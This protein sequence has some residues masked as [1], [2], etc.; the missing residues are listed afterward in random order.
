MAEYEGIKEIVNQVAAQAPKAI[1]M[2]FRDMDQGSWPAPPQQAKE[3]HKDKGIMN[4][5][6]K[7]PHSVEML[8]T[9][10]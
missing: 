5:Y 1:T 3:S 7:S 8:R 4:C 6:M 9:G 10:I 2:A